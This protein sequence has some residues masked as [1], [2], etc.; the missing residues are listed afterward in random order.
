MKSEIF[1]FDRVHILLHPSE[2]G[3]LLVKFP[4]DS[5]YKEIP[6]TSLATRILSFSGNLLISQGDESPHYASVKRYVLL[7]VDETNATMCED[8]VSDKEFKVRLTAF[9]DILIPSGAMIIDGKQ[10]KDLPNNR[11]RI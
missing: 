10:Y 6:K 9:L 8:G 1:V 5:S 2:K 7:S 11:F 3:K 4:T